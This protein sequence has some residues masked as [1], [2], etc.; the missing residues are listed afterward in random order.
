MAKIIAKRTHNNAAAFVQVKD[1][2][3]TVY[4]K[5]YGGHPDANIEIPVPAE[6]QF[7]IDV[8]DSWQSYKSSELEAFCADCF[9]KAAENDSWFDIFLPK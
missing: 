2:V 5:F 4:G 8:L 9:R 1:N 6:L 7:E 3:A